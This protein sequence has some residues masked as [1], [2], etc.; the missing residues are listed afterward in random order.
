MKRLLYLGFAFP[1]GV[2]AQFPEINP[3][4]HAFETQMLAALRA[5]FEI[6]SAGVLPVVAPKIPQP[7]EAASGVAH[8]LVLL[9][10]APELWHRL[11]SLAQLKRHFRQWLA[12]GWRPDAVLVYNF[13]PI[14]NNFLRWLKRQPSPP[15]FI[16][17]LLDS[18]HLGRALPRWKRLRHRL[19]PL[20][21][22]DAEM[23]GEFD[24][25]IGLSQ[26]AE[27][28]FAPRQ[29]PFLWMP[30]GCQPERAPTENAPASCDS[31]PIRFGYFG[32]L[33]PHSGALPMVETF[34]A[35]AW[36]NSL[37][38]CGHG[39]QSETVAQLARRDARMQFHG[40][41]PSPDACLRLA[42]SWDVLINP[43][44]AGFGNENNFPSKIFEYGLCARAILT[45]RMS[46][47]DS[48]LGPE[49]F[50]FDAGNFAAE[51]NLQ[52]S[53]L[54]ALPRAELRRR[55]NALRERVT[56]Q[57]AW[58]KQAASMAAFICRQL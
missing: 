16:L 2:Q 14:Y 37:H 56:A 45:T 27:K 50:Y 58:P 44:P 39:K 38:I 29:V 49:A 36:S 7:T 51:L 31:S 13:S 55:G 24:A 54:A 57:Y 42:Q 5:H 11:R 48:V 32:A 21:I 33:A 40:L 10:R 8:E 4:G 22:P 26:A 20:V 1:P 18:A 46:G 35:S 47:V 43:R 9:E 6:K 17:L 25:C 34:L 3:A 41:Q 30:G 23:L 52:L 12:A 53:A 19:K 28:F 15:K